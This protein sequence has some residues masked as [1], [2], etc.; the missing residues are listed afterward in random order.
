[1]SY[2]EAPVKRRI[3]KLLAVLAGS[4]VVCVVLPGVWFWFLTSLPLPDGMVVMAIVPSNLVL[5]ASAPDV[6]KHTVEVNRPLPSVLGFARSK[7]TDGKIV[8][9]AIRAFSLTDVA[10]GMSAWKLV[11]EAE[12]SISSKKSPWEVFGTPWRQVVWLSIW[13]KKLLN[14]QSDSLPEVLSGVYSKN[15][16]H[17]NVNGDDL[18]PLGSVTSSNTMPLTPALN[19]NLANFTSANGFQ[20][21]FPEKGL[22]GWETKAGHLDLI[23]QPELPIDNSTYLGLAQGYDLFD[24]KNSLLQD[25]TAI[26]V[27]SP[28][29]D[30][31]ATS[32]LFRL[33][34]FSFQLPS[35]MA[36]DLLNKSVRSL[37]CPGQPVALF[38]D[39]SLKNICSWVDICFFTPR[40]M[41]ITK[42]SDGVNFCV[43]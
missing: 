12:L 39:V 34:Q 26:Q 24:K 18:P 20:I 21:L 11:T 5:P 6:W 23:V 1:M 19:H 38:N 10:Q 16:W 30:L 33:K 29:T 17:V 13:P 32:S 42:Q 4:F 27:L 22:L 14:S 35:S 31:S 25:R 9:F 7:A 3:T 43:E 8:P 15:I 41:I 37:A 28:P 40:Q 36:P 2:G